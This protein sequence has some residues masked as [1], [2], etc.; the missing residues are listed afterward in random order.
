MLAAALELRPAA[1]QGRLDVHVGSD[2]GDQGYVDLVN[3]CRGDSDADTIDLI[4]DNN[5]DGATSALVE[6]PEVPHRW[7]ARHPGDRQVRLRTAR[8]LR[9]APGRLAVPPGAPERRLLMS[10]ATR[11]LERRHDDVHRRRRGHLLERPVRPRRLRR[12]VRDVQPRALRCRSGLAWQRRERRIVPHRPG[13][14]C[15]ERRRSCLPG[16]PR[17]GPVYLDAGAPAINVTCQKWD[18]KTNTW[19][20]KAPR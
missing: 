2:F 13:G 10:T 1:D 7:P 6:E 18:S 16:L 14:A 19:V 9:R 12:K 3:G 4:V 17:V 5:A 11:T 15:V 8:R 20:D